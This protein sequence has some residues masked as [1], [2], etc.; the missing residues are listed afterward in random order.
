VVDAGHARV[1]KVAPVDKKVCETLAGM[2]KLAYLCTRKRETGS[3]NLSG[4]SLTLAPLAGEAVSE[5]RLPDGSIREA[6]FEMMTNE[7]K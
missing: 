1:K 3:L 5:A 4:L 6:F 2:E 7:T